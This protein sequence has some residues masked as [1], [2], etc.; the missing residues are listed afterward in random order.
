MPQFIVRMTKP[1]SDLVPVKGW[2]KTR[3]V[4]ILTLSDSSRA[5]K[6]PLHDFPEAKVYCIPTAHRIMRKATIEVEGSVE[7][8][9]TQEDTHFVFSRPK[10]YTP[11]H[12]ATWENEDIRCSHLYSQK[13]EVDEDT[14]YTTEFRNLCRVISD[15]IFYLDTS[16]KKVIERV[17]K[18]P[19]FLHYEKQRVLHL[20]KFLDHALSTSTNLSRDEEVRLFACNIIPSLKSIKES[21]QAVKNSLVNNENLEDILNFHEILQNNC[22]KCLEIISEFKLPNICPRVLILTDAGP[23]VGISNY[24]QRFR[25]A[26]LGD[27]IVDG[28]TLNW[29]I[30]KRFEDVTHKKKVKNEL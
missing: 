5:R 23:G 14:Q 11:S 10:Y 29:E 15:S 8:L 3:N 16:E 20:E 13:F 4:K 12:G 18:D 6:L 28:G 21:L 25:D 7:K 2:K 30:F 22:S 9:I 1:T 27:A 24:E 26:E 17:K 19:T